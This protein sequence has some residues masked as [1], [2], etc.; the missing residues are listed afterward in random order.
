M[1]EQH[2]ILYNA[3]PLR[4]VH[5]ATGLWQHTGG[6]A[7]SVSGLCAALARAGCQVTLVTLDGPMADAVWA[8]RDEGVELRLCAP[9]GSQAVG[10]SREMVAALPGLVAT[11]Q[12]VHSH[13]H[14]QYPNW[15]AA[16]V[17]RQ[18][19]RPLVISPRGCLDPWCLRK[20][21]WKKRLAAALFGDRVLRQATCLHATAAAE[22]E[23]FRRYGLHTLTTVVPNGVHFSAPG[24]PDR[25][26]DRFP[27]CRGKRLLLYLSRIHPVKGVPFLIEAWQALAAA[28]PRWHLLLAGPDERGHVAEVLEAVK[29]AGLAARTTYAGPLYGDD[30]AAAFAAAELFV[31]PTQSENFGIAIAEALAAGVPVLTTQGAP[32]EGILTQHCG[33][34]VPV[35]AAPLTTALREALELEQD[36]LRAMGSRGQLWVRAT[37]TWEAVARDMI[38]TYRWIIGQ[39]S[40]PA[41]VVDLGLDGVSP[42]ENDNR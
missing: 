35:G 13:G 33:W 38:A 25:I 2:E 42:R 20:S 30:R 9:T 27:A 15:L 19:Q 22:A 37:F 6:P 36:T 39:G 23:A 40:R 3:T 10:Y 8:C 7:A 21:R 14:W 41:S 28:H 1:P 16:A 11:A 17:A 26:L 5:V 18:R 34:W 32:W 31:L 4:V 24:T 12:M 29:R